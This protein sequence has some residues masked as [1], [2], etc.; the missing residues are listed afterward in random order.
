MGAIKIPKIFIRRV[1][2]Q[3]VLVKKKK[4]KIYQHSRILRI[5]L[6]TNDIVCF[7]TAIKTEKKIP[8]FIFI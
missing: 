1:K 5:N 2:Q 4:K 8:P 6:V 7:E 3:V